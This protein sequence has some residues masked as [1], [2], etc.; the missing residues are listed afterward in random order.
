V[1]IIRRLRHQAGITQQELATSAGTSQSTIASYETGSKSPTVRTVEKLARSQNLEL[2]VDFKPPMT[3]EDLR[4]LVFHREIAN[5]LRQNP[6]YVIRHARKNLEKL[7]S[8]HPDAGILFEKWQEW[9]GL[10]L[11]ILLEKI[12]DQRPEACEMRQVSPFSGLL[13]A[14]Q[15]SQVLR[16]FREV[17]PA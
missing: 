17:Y 11:D 16:A 3:R 12:Q 10:P 8:I 9:L 2:N 14:Q 7:A 5:L 6:E 1:N 13:N 4:S 15:R